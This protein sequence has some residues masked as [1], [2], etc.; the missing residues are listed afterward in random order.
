MSSVDVEGA[1]LCRNLENSSKAVNDNTFLIFYTVT[2]MNWRVVT[3]IAEP[4]E[5]IAASEENMFLI[6]WNKNYL[7]FEFI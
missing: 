4:V 3:K 2:L 7:Y 6:N 5:W 1:G